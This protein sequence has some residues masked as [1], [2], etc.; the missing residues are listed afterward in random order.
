M[1]SLIPNQPVYMFGQYLQY[2][3]KQTLFDGVYVRLYWLLTI[4]FH[5]LGLDMFWRRGF[6]VTAG[7]KGGIYLVR[8]F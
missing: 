5:P 8:F 1:Y 3:Y 4:G 6:S 7:E 2:R